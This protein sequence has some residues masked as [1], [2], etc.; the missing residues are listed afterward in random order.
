MEMVAFLIAMWVTLMFAFVCA[1]DGLST[2]ELG[3]SLQKS[4]IKHC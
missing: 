4:Y 1:T 3:I 2:E